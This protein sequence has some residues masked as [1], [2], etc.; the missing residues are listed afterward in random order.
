LVIVAGAELEEEESEV[1]DKLVFAVEGF[2]AE[3]AWR[4]SLESLAICVDLGLGFG[5]IVAFVL[6]GFG[7][8]VKSTSSE[9]LLLE[10]LVSEDE[11]SA[12]AG[13][14]AAID[15]AGSLEVSLVES[16][17]DDELSEDVEAAFAVATAGL[18]ASGSDSLSEEEVPDE[19]ADFG[20]AE[21]A[22]MAKLLT[23][24]F[25]AETAFSFSTESESEPEPELDEVEEVAFRFKLVAIPFL[26]GFCVNWGFGNLAPAGSF[27]SSASLSEFE[28]DVDDEGDFDLDVLVTLL[29]GFGAIVAS[30]ISTSESLSILLLP[31][32]PLLLVSFL[33]RTAATASSLALDPAF[34]RFFDFL[35]F[36]A[37][38][39][40]ELSLL[41]LL[42]ALLVSPICVRSWYNLYHSLKTLTRSG[43]PLG[44]LASSCIF[45]SSS[46]FLD[47][48]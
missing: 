27:S 31:L 35:D 2:W 5:V 3:V 47:C 11:V 39:V 37:D 21:F 12:F 33:A 1:E 44:S 4:V 13:V 30:F 46:F 19:V 17:S 28:L 36:L 7:G 26:A 8:L 10:E 6:V 34:A 18:E 41:S 15:A 9:S 32:S 25:L 43:N 20:S 16:L 38:L 42:L 23:F 48:N 22:G 29:E 45:H 14:G 24:G 40:S